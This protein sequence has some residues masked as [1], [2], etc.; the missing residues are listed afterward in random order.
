VINSE[1][2]ALYQTGFTLIEL[3]TVVVISAILLVIAV[4]SFENLIK[5]SNVDSIQ[6]KLSSAFA[7]ART[8]AA[9]RNKVVA[10]C[11]SN[12]RATCT[13]NHWND[14]WIVHE[15][16]SVAAI[17]NDELIDVYSNDA[18]GYTITLSAP[19][20]TVA[21]NT[22]SFSSQG[23]MTTGSTARLLTICEPDK[24]VAYARGLY[25]N[26]S[27][28]VMKT[29]DGIDADN[30]HDDPDPLTAATNLVCP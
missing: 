14:G 30:T 29:R 18:D 24:D 27:G 3:M 26:T 4:P 9:S 7:T 5:R 1:T 12:D 23:F 22:I 16:D 2:K 19:A 10:I 8:E 21:Q 20:T 28:L 6:S 25:I 13:G 15:V 17:S 11:A